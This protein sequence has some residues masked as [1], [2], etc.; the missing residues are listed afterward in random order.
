MKLQ[1]LLASMAVTSALFSAGAMAAD[2]TIDFNGRITASACTVTGAAQSGGATSTYTNVDLAPV[3]VGS[4]TTVG[5]YAGHKPFSIYLTGC[6]ATASLTNVYTAFTTPSPAAEDSGVMANILLSAPAT[7]VGVAILNADTF[8]Q[9][10]MNAGSN[11]DAPRALPAAG[12]PAAMQL[13]YVAAVK[14][15]S[16]PVT[17][18]GVYGRATYIVTYN[19]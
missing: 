1:R 18:G 12:S 4:L 13:N 6:E 10:D 7:G 8:A 15:L 14:V 17:A 19:N 11:A 3:S 9:I 2:G 16:L 5:T